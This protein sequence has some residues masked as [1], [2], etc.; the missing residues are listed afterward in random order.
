MSAETHEFLKASIK[1]GNAKGPTNYQ[2]SQTVFHHDD[3]PPSKRERKHE[4]L[5]WKKSKLLSSERSS[6]DQSYLTDKPVC[7]RRTMEN[8]VHDRSNRYE[9][10]VYIVV[11]TCGSDIAIITARRQWNTCAMWSPSTIPAPDTSAISSS[12]WR[13]RP[14]RVPMQRGV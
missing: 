5:E 9:F 11:L 2:A 1:I 7:E 12:L 10:L 14:R 6:W 4:V 3:I 13:G 8:H